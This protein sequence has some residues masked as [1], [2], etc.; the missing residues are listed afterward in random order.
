MSNDIVRVFDFEGR[1]LTVV[2]YKG[3]PAYIAKE[4]GARLG[5]ARNGGKL[6]D[7]ITGKWGK[8]FVSGEHYIVL[9]GKELSDFKN[10]FEA[11]TPGV[12]T[13]V[14]NLMLIFKPGMYKVAL[15]S[16]KPE[17]EPLIDFFVNH[18]IPQMEVDGRYDPNRSIDA[19]GNIVGGVSRYSLQE[20]SMAI[21]ERE[22]AIK[23]REM[24]LKEKSSVQ[25]EELIRIRA[26]VADRLKKQREGI[27]LRNAAK[28]R[29]KL[30]GRSDEREYLAYCLKAW[31]MEAGGRIGTWD[32]DS[33][34]PDGGRLYTPA[35]IAKAEGVSENFVGR[36]VTRIGKRL[37]IKNIREDDRYTSPRG[38]MIEYDDGSKFYPNGYYMR[39][40][41]RDKVVAEIMEWKS[42]K[43]KNRQT[44]LFN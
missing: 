21:K 14:S 3:K 37:G 39:E 30:D 7:M 10:L 40:N 38:H 4:F 28:I 36:M 6:S 1:P 8:F 11:I 26:G 43:D 20:R 34:S 13:R 5:Y 22:V 9:R 35:E 12:F 16:G 33:Y 42:K 19:S 31:E 32:S 44:S 23:E 24:T 2:T 41:L 15:K 17:V 18:V 29:M 27:A 25:N